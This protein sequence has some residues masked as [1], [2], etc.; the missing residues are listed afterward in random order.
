MNHLKWGRKRGAEQKLTYHSSCKGG[1]G[2]YHMDIGVPEPD[3]AG[4]EAAAARLSY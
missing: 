4:F 2:V 3:Q 1:A